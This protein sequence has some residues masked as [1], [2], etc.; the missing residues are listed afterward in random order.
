MLWLRM[1]LLQLF[2]QFFIQKRKFSILTLL[3]RVTN[4]VIDGGSTALGPVSCNRVPLASALKFFFLNWFIGRFNRVLT[5]NKSKGGLKD[6]KTTEVG[7]EL[8]DGTQNY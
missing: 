7:H 2:K 8:S 1:R 4:S 6:C 3:F 5:S